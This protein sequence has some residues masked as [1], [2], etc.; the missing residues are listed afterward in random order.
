MAVESVCRFSLHLL[1]LA[2]KM[3]DASTVFEEAAD[4]SPT[5]HEAYQKNLYT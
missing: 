1:S 2:L 4:Q 3:S 5:E